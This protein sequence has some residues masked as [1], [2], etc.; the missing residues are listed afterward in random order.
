MPKILTTFQTCT[1]TNL[2]IAKMAKKRERQ[3]GKANNGIDP[4]RP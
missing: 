3:E 1:F 2:A 4:K